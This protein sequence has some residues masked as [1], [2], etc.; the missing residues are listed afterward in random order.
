MHAAPIRAPNLTLAT[1]ADTWRAR[2]ARHWAPRTRIGY[3]EKLRLYVLPVLGEVALDAITRR[4]LVELFDDLATRHQPATVLLTV[5]ILTALFN[6][7]VDGEWLTAN[8]AFRLARRYRSRKKEA[9][10]YAPAETEL[11]LR[12]AYRLDPVWAVGFACMAKAGV[13]TGE[14]RA[15]RLSDFDRVEKRV[16]IRRQLTQPDGNAE[17]PKGGKTRRLPYFASLEPWL[18]DAAMRSHDVLVPMAAGRWGYKQT[19]RTC[20]RIAERAKLPIYSPKAFRHGFASTLVSHGESVESVRAAMGHADI[21]TTVR[22]YGGHYE[23]LRSGLWDR[24]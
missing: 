12:T 2:R 21:R 10:C 18:D 13:R 23:M 16:A 19:L 17:L 20:R 9:P 15:L 4:S 24:L 22:T 11:F 5:G 7:A 14:M 8:P 3:E 1:Y 6:D